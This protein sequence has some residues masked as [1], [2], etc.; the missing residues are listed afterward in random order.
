LSGRCI[1]VT[2]YTLIISIFKYIGR[3]DRSKEQKKRTYR[4]SD[5]HTKILWIDDS[6]VNSAKVTVTSKSIIRRSFN[7]KIL[8]FSTLNQGSRPGT[9]Y[10]SQRCCRV[11]FSWRLSLQGRFITIAGRSLQIYPHYYKI[12]D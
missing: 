8:V 12:L 9:K 10:F 6:S 11:C 7:A 1:R 2:D 4:Y 3:G 5:S